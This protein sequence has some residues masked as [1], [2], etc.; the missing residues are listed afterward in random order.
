MILF[1]AQTTLSIVLAT[2]ICLNL[3]CWKLCFGVGC[4]WIWTWK[5]MA[6]WVSNTCTKCMVIWFSLE[7]GD[8]YVYWNALTSCIRICVFARVCVL[9]VCVRACVCARVFVCVCV[10]AFH[11]SVCVRACVCLSVCMRVCLCVRARVCTFM[12]AYTHSSV[13]NNLCSDNNSDCT[14]KYDS[15]ITCYLFSI[16]SCICACFRRVLRTDDHGDCY[17]RYR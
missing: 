8:L 3:N 10:R 1:H 16:G 13:W 6:T 9:C 15:Y 17:G 4:H 14:L 7:R 12:S 5:I 11:V 2:T